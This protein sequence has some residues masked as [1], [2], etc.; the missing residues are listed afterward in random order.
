MNAQ[1]PHGYKRANSHNHF[2]DIPPPGGQKSDPLDTKA[3][4]VFQT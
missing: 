4:Q 3:H 1:Q 2:Y